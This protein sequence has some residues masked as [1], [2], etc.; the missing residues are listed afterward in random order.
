M[1]RT[2]RFNQNGQSLIFL[3]PNEEEIMLRKLRE[4]KIPIED[5]YVDPRKMQT[6]RFKAQA[7][8]AGDV[9]LKESAQRAF[10][11]Y[12]K[13]IH[14]MKDKEVF[15]VNAIDREKYATSLGLHVAPQIGFLSK[16]SS[17]GKK[18]SETTD[19]T[20]DSRP[21]DNKEKQIS[22]FC[23]DSDDE[24]GDKDLFTVKSTWRAG[25]IPVPVP[26][27][28]LEDMSRKK[29]KIVSKAAVVKKLVK[30][31]I[32][33]NTKI[34][35]NDEGKPVESFPT[36]QT[37]EKLKELE[38][39]NVIDI[40]V[41]KE[42]MKEED[43]IDREVRRKIRLEKKRA[44]IEKEKGPK[45][46]KKAKEADKDNDAEEDDDLDETTAAYIDMLPDPDVVYGDKN[47]EDE[48]YS[49][50]DRDYNDGDSDENDNDE[51]EDDKPSK[52]RRLASSSE[53]EID[54]DFELPDNEHLAL[55]L[56][57]S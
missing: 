4:R 24:D 13:S 1:G 40:E 54:E 44:R 32:Q 21:S 57:R 33:I 3:M 34:V 35:F 41:A 8:C 49:G 6:I 29:G 53:D 56:L 12:I 38:G 22:L 15:N 31:G 17:K 27:I 47:E 7:Y 46:N 45:K 43:E 50:D 51:D 26:D 20:D 23:N 9:A 16:G 10:K 14:L 2:A 18:D 39:K 11:A 19:K 55:Q 30:K 52:K 5:L 36:K 42:I 48:E 37:S 25:D 28:S